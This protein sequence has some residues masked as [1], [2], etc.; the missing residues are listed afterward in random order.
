MVEW[1][2]NTITIKSVID[3]LWTKNGLNSRLKL[4][5]NKKVIQ[6]GLIQ[7]NKLEEMMNAPPVLTEYFTENF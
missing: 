5:E 3:N 7:E 4:E 1:V 2:P 6:D